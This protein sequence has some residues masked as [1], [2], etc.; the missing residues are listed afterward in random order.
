MPG[1][2]FAFDVKGRISDHQ[3]RL[4]R[5]L[6]GLIHN[7][8]IHTEILIQND[9]FFLGFS[10]YAHYEITLFD[11]D[12]YTI[13]LEGRIYNK[14]R[15]LLRKEL[16][17]LAESLFQN[18]SGGIDSLQSWMSGADGEYAV[19]M[20][21]NERPE[22]LMFND[23]LGHLP[24]YSA[25]GD[26][27]LILSREIAFMHAFFKE[28]ALDKKAI[29]QFLLFSF[30]LGTRTLLSGVE[31]LL[32]GTMVSKTRESN[33]I[34]SSRVHLF[35]FEQKS[36][37]G[38]SRDENIQNLIDIFYES[39]R[40]RTAAFPQQ[41]NILSL[42][43]GLDSRAVAAGLFKNHLP[44]EAVTYIDWAKTATGDVIVA[45]EIAHAMHAKWHLEQLNPPKGRDFF[46]LLRMKFGMNY[47]GMGFIM[48]YLEYLKQVYGPNTVYFSGDTGMVLRDYRSPRELR[49]YR[50][51]IRFIFSYGGRYS[52]HAMFSVD[53]VSRIVRISREE[54]LEDVRKE[55]ESYPEKDYN[56]KYVHFTYSGYCFN[57]HYEGIDR[58][59]MFFWLGCPLE[60]FDFFTYAMNC[61]DE[62]KKYY[63]FYR[64]FLATMFPESIFIDNATWGAPVNSPN[65]TLKSFLKNVYLEMP[66]FIKEVNRKWKLKNPS[67][68][69]NLQKCF[70]QQLASNRE[71][72]H[73]LSLPPAE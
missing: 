6:N 21:H 38:R 39:C 46:H 68:R 48:P 17:A 29:A 23:P 19:I 5:S 40:R 3:S 37:A 70:T 67:G 30:P 54:I 13:V 27:L 45:K 53:E 55:L 57:W 44:F 7:D 73:Y 4:I 62:Q 20:V 35:N 9:H 11:S 42:S 58:N 52:S 65:V 71:I 49:S 1:I 43:G 63:R 14:T 10:K 72:E 47:L 61:D 56:Q 24:V 8:H 51:I 50:D 28:N 22:F 34:Q 33:N 15:S 26:G 18:N 2:C 59:R 66:S 41:R 64:Q 31:K 69:S 12:D 60:S 25:S 16:T 36:H 32:P